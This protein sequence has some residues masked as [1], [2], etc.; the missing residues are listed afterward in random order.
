M[1]ARPI[2]T[3]LYLE[4]P[5]VYVLMYTKERTCCYYYIYA[6]VDSKIMSVNIHSM[7]CK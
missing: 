2:N 7:S 1:K 4:A 3:M 5:T 6:L